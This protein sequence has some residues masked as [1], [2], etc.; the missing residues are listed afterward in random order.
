MSN[1]Q[2]FS[3]R[4]KV[5][6][7]TGASSGFGAHFARV[8]ASEGAKVGLAARR[9]DALESIAAQIREAGGV[10]A[11]TKLD[12]ADSASVRQAVQ[13]IEQALGR[14]DVLVN[15]SGV[16]IGKPLLEQTEEDF[17]AVLNVNLRGAFLVATEVARRMKA[18]GKGGSIINIE[19]ILSFRQAGQ[20]A[21]YAASKAGLTQLTRSMALELARYKIRVNGIAPGY[22]ATDINKE[23]FDTD[24]GLAMIKRMPSRRLGELEELEGPLLLLASDAS[25]YM[26]GATVVVDGGHLSSNL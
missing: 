3:V 7:I 1:S 26:S 15:N 14:I 19:S 24:G 9:V 13:A 5:V 4:G 25:S 16:S 20:I 8:L 11:T 18:G 2:R 23:F 17:D 12:V 6:L 22:F 21:P 10:A